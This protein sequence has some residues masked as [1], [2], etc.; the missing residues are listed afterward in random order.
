MLSDKGFCREK[1]TAA[2]LKGRSRWQQLR[3]LFKLPRGIVQS[4]WILIRFRPNLVIGVGGYSAGPVILSAWLLRIKTVLHE[5]NV[6]PGM[7]NR[8][9]ARF[10]NGVFVSFESTRTYFSQKHVRVT[11]NPVRREILTVAR[12]ALSSDGPKEVFTVLIAGG[13]QG[14]HSINM[15]V[16]AALEHLTEKN[17]FF[18]I[19]QTGPVDERTVRTGYELSGVR[20]RVLPFIKDMAAVYRDADLIICR[21]GATTVAEITAMG[22]AAIMIPFPYATDD[23]QTINAKDLAQQGAAEMIL[24]KDLNGHLLA[25]RIEFYA[26]HPERLH[27][28]KSAA[29]RL[30]N[31]DAAAVIVDECYRLLEMNNN[32]STIGNRTSHYV[33]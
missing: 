26:D 6:L 21:A 32:P 9:L 11:G 30:G 2:G 19:H 29:E 28:M 12:N 1:I 18:F 4:L 8:M 22:K 33:F 23:H 31:P 3:S 25:Q 27:Q 24:D 5:Q 16:L 14:A 20:A 17:R 10:A 13:S 7:T 15:A